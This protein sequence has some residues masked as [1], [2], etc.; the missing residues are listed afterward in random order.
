M[1]IT[2]YIM[3]PPD[4][5]YEE[6]A[7]SLAQQ[8]KVN[9]ALECYDLA[10]TSNPDNDVILNSK[11]IALISLDRFKE[12]LETTKRAAAINP[13][14][15]DVWINMGVALEK[16]DRPQEASEALERAVAISPYNA[17]ARALLG[18]I[19]QNMD[20]GEKA[21]AQNRKLQ[22]IVF[23]KGYAGFFFATAAFL[24]GILLGGIQGVEGRPPTISLTSQVIIVVFFCIICWLYWRSLK[25]WTEINRNV[26]LVPVPSMAKPGRGSKVM[27]FILVGMVIVFAVGILTGNGVWTWLH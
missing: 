2:E 26:I 19:Y 16:L 6:Q 10:L 13:A 17:Y 22:E 5:P 4:S 27:Y 3:S 12:A 15:V 20:M 24:L 8:G 7:A 11:A 14:A 21:E 25:M 23:P 18:I 1:E 9:E